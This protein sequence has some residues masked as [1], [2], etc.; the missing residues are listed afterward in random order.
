MSPDFQPCSASAVQA[1]ILAFLGMPTYPERGK[2]VKLFSTQHQLPSSRLAVS[3]S[4]GAV[5]IIF[6][7]F[8]FI[9]TLLIHHDGS[10]LVIFFKLLLYFYVIVQSNSY[11][12]V[13]QLPFK[14]I[15]LVLVCL[16]KVCYR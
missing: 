7:L 11:V 2:P 1:V 16:A 8:K 4:T 6:I 10:S 14:F 5:I 9:A 13:I 12:Y 15:Y 3:A